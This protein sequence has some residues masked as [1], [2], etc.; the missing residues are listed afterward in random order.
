MAR[1]ERAA[2]RQGVRVRFRAYYGPA[3]LPGDEVELDPETAAALTR[4]G[5]A[6]YVR[7][8]GDRAEAVQSAE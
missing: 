5:V 6:E 7:P 8:E 1:Q 4:A 2:Q 3:Y